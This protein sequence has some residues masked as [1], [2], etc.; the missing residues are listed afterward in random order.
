MAMNEKWRMIH[1]PELKEIRKVWHKNRIAKD[2]EHNIKRKSRG[3]EIKLGLPA[4]WYKTQF[5][6]QEGLC[7]L[8]G[9]PETTNGTRKHTKLEK[10]LAIDHCHNRMVARGLLCMSCN[11]RLSV[12]EDK[13]FVTLATAYL[14]KYQ[15]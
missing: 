14:A 2:P 8:C 12:L 13:E 10:R 7:A 9:K 1:E 3:W 4:G 11:T 5:E 15:P 6:I